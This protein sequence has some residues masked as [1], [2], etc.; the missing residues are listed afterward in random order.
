M[1]IQEWEN[2]F[3]RDQ[4][5]NVDRITSHL[6]DGDVF[7][8]IGANTGKLTQL[9]YHKLKGQGKEL[10]KLILFEPVPRYY[11]ECVKKFGDNPKFWINNLALSNDTETKT[12]YVS[13]RNWG[14]NKIYKEGMEIHPHDKLEIPCDTFSNWMFNKGIDKI[15]FIKIDAEGHDKEVIEGMFEWLRK[16]NQRPYIQFEGT[17]YPNEEKDL[18]ETLKIDFNYKFDLQKTDYLLYQ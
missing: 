7:V 2:H 13:H 3:Q 12:L 15:D 14:Y 5:N 8:D 6:K 10:D 9:I 18:L 11:D 1:N 16:T 4:G 17:W